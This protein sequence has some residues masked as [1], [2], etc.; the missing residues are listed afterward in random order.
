MAILVTGVLSAF[1]YYFG[2]RSTGTTGRGEEKSVR[3]AVKGQPWA[4][5]EVENS[6]RNNYKY[7]YHPRGDV[8][9]PPRRAPSALNSVIVPGV[10]L[11]KVGFPF[12]RR[13]SADGAVRKFMRSL[14]SMGRI[15]IRNGNMRER[16]ERWMDRW[17]EEML[18]R[19]EHP[20][21]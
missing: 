19:L 15:T 18:C 16:V 9:N 4:A 11:P 6:D 10:T 5:K 20:D 17:L 3:V 2:R 14:I 8:N 1:G 7:M 12:E 21:P 13:H